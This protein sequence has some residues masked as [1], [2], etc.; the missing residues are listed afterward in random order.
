MLSYFPKYRISART[1]E[2]LKQNEPI[3]W[4]NAEDD[5]IA[6][7]KVLGRKGFTEDQ[8]NR[9]ISLAVLT[10]LGVYKRTFP[11]AA[12]EPVLATG[13]EPIEEEEPDG[14]H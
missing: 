13:G 1:A 4:A 5:L 11:V 2:T 14:E 6:R 7:N 10:E 9:L 8:M 12:S 3:K